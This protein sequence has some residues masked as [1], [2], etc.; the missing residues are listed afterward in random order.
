MP[1]P[2]LLLL[3]AIGGALA[4]A[5]RPR[6]MAWVLVSTWMLV[7]GSMRVPGTGSGQLFIHRAVIA[8]VVLG[9]LREHLRGRLPPHAFAIRG[10]HLAF[11]AFLGVALA[12]GVVLAEP[13][14]PAPLNSNTYAGLVEQAVFFVVALAV[15]RSIGAWHAAVRITVVAGILAA[16]AVSEGI[17]SWSYSQWL[18]RHVGDPLGLLSLDLTT[19][20]QNER[21]RAAATFALE[22]G[23]ITALLIPLTV[24]TAMAAR[25]RGRLLWGVPVT[26]VVA[27]VW[28]WSRSAYAGLAVGLFVLA[29]AVVVDRPH[30]AA[31]LAVL[32]LGFGAALLQGPLRTTLDLGQTRGEQD[33]RFQRLPELLD[34]ASDRPLGGLGLGGLLVRRFEAVDLSWVNAYATIGL[35]GII[36]LVAL[37][38]TTAHAATRFLLCG[39]SATRLLAAGAAAGIIV[40][41]VGMAAYD[42]LSLR[43]STQTVWGLSAL[44]L[45]AGEELGVLPVPLRRRAQSVPRPA[46]AL[47]L[48][49]L[50]AGFGLALS[51][52][53]VYSIDAVFTTVDPRSIAVA[54][55]DNPYSGKVLGQTG[56]LV[57]DET[58]FEASVD[59]RD[60]DR[61][62]GGVGEVRIEGHDRETVLQGYE[63]VERTVSSVFPHAIVTVV[64]ERSGRPT[65]AVTAPVWMLAVGFALGTILPDR[66][67]RTEPVRRPRHDVPSR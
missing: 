2:L 38:L 29:L 31:P 12:T 53:P 61:I 35:V 3:V 24:A 43:N 20:G 46:V 37:L 17:L 58:D 45:A 26:L 66:A 60:I 63:D 15:F 55:R 36:A 40:A 32:G 64:D 10:A 42:L 49:G 11:V 39:P 19:R 22:L 48:L 27:M 7:P 34:L 33:V 5:G 8:A 16:I 23:W 67:Y 18:T 9:L 25:G 56:C 52:P 21:V 14:I 13:R 65:W 30:R 28:T 51:V 1:A 62:P 57:I 54:R 59:C 4:I 41:P 6:T 47:Q 44:A 50:T